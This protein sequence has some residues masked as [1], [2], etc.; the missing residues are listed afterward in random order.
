[1]A[2]TPG[3]VQTLTQLGVSVRVERGA[4]VG[5]GLSDREYAQADAEL[6]DA[7]GAWSC[8]MVVKVKEPVEA[9]YRYLRPDLLLFTYLHLAADRGASL[10]GNVGHRL[11]NGANC[12]RRA[13]P[14]A[15]HE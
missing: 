8:E 14:P 13:A 2:L 11:R 5:S 6:T 3:D 4:G 1:M 9:E 12:A 15:A 10:G 7:A